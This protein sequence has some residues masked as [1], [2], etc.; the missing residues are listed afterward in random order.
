MFDIKK[1]KKKSYSFITKQNDR[2]FFH[3]FFLIFCFFW[4]NFGRKSPRK[5]VK[6]EKT[7]K[8]ATDLESLP[9]GDSNGGSHERKIFLM[10]FLFKNKRSSSEPKNEK[11]EFISPDL[12]GFES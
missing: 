4:H 8:M 11:M 7:I 6:F 12:E 1:S 3:P 5:G 2:F 9:P 10:L